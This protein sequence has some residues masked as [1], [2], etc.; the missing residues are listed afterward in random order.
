MGTPSLPD[1]TSPTLKTQSFAGFRR[2]KP[3]LLV[4]TAVA[5]APKD[6]R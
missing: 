5:E 2:E 6:V 3:E 1:R 4:A